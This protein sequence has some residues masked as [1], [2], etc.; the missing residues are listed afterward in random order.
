MDKEDVNYNTAWCPQCFD[1]LE[2]KNILNDEGLIIDHK[3]EC[4]GCE[5]VY[6]LVEE[7]EK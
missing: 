5:K 2:T 3:Y 1:A 6:K 4:F 7:V